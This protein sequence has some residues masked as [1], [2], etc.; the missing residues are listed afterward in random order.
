MS[1]NNRPV[2][3]WRRNEADRIL[4]ASQNTPDVWRHQSSLVLGQSETDFADDANLT[5]DHEWFFALAKFP[6]KFQ[7]LLPRAEDFEGFFE[8]R[9][10]AHFDLAGRIRK[11]GGSANLTVIS[12]EYFD[13]GQS[14]QLYFNGIRPDMVAILWLYSNTGA[15]I[16]P[17]PSL[18]EPRHL[19]RR[20][21]TVRQCI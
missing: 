12:A 10:A 6:N 13:D 2:I 11:G 16:L 15:V 19:R 21:T 4:A 14:I 8:G 20:S 5:L 9:Y 18:L 1:L 3:V 7:Y 17:E